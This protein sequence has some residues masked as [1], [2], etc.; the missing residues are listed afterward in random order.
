V[1]SSVSQCARQN[2]L[3]QKTKAY[4]AKK[5]IRPLATKASSG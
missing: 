2:Y 3:Q 1:L 4:H 5:S